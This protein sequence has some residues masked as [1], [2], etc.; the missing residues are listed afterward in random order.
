MNMYVIISRAFIHSQCIFLARIYFRGC[1]LKCDKPSCW[2]WKWISG[3]IEFGEAAEQQIWPICAAQLNA[4]SSLL[5]IDL[6]RQKQSYQYH[7]IIDILHTVCVS[8]VSL[9]IVPC[10][11]NSPSSVAFQPQILFHPISIAESP[12]EGHIPSS[13]VRDEYI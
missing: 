4:G 7:R 1:C 3:R 2:Q 10:L 11:G 5:E 12:S 9:E 13:F 8:L 6:A